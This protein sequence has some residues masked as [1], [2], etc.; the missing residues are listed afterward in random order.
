MKMKMN[1]DLQDS[2]VRVMRTTFSVCDIIQ[3][4]RDFVDTLIEALREVVDKVA[5]AI[6]GIVDKF[7]VLFDDTEDIEFKE[8]TYPHFYPHYVDNLKVDTK[9]Y[10]VKFH[11]FRC[12]RSRC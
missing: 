6:R 1:D 3:S 11:S 12:A 9:G 7:S 10:P 4:V 2:W 5:E 8:K